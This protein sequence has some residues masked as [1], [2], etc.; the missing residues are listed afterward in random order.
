MIDVIEALFGR[1]E[2]VR[3]FLLEQGEPTYASEVESIAPKVL[4]LASASYFES[5]VVGA[6][7]GYFTARLGEGDIGEEFVRR[8]AL[9]RQYHALFDWTAANVNKFW[10]LFGPHFKTYAQAVVD[11]DDQ[12]REGVRAFL[13]LGR[14]RN[15]MVHENYL[16]FALGKTSQ[17]VVDL[18]RLGNV[19]VAR[20]VDLIDAYEAPPPTP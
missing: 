6:V 17:E 14:L 12:L 5:A 13:E 18:A 3:A 2:E 4:L 8:K 9:E 1:Y 20:L 7:A 11:A 10:S 15:E 16:T 19:F